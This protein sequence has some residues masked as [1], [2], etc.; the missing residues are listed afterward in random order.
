[1]P[2][3]PDVTAVDGDSLP[4]RLKECPELDTAAELRVVAK[5]LVVSD[6]PANDVLRRVRPVDARDEMLGAPGRQ[7]ALLPLYPARRTEPRSRH[8]LDRDRVVTRINNTPAKQ[9]PPPLPLHLHP[10]SPLSL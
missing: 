6:E 5:Q 3:L 7:V 1:M 4:R 10:A 9:H 8:D 2:D